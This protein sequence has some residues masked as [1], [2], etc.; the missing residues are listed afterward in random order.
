[1]NWDLHLAADGMRDLHRLDPW[2][3]EEVLDEL[4]RL[5]ANPS[6]IPPP[7][8]HIGIVHPIVRADGPSLRVVVVSLLRNDFARLLSFLGVREIPD[9][10]SEM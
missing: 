1:V 3:Q 5:A 7:L 9:Q 4:E 6:L 10:P 2:L 8:P